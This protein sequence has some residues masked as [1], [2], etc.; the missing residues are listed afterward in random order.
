VVVDLEVAWAEHCE[1]EVANW[2]AALAH[3]LVDKEVVA[4]E[5]A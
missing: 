4:Q 5:V 3:S 1:T 2:G